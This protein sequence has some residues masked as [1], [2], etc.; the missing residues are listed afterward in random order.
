LP[1]WQKAREAEN[2]VIYHEMTGVSQVAS[3]CGITFCSF[4]NKL[5]LSNVLPG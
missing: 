4:S 2:G 5:F 1:E 3:L